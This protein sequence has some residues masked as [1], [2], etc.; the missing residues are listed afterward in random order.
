MI[1]SP[2]RSPSLSPASSSIVS[3]E[4]CVISTLLIPEY[5][6]LSRK[7]RRAPDTPLRWR[8]LRCPDTVKVL[9]DRPR[10]L[11]RFQLDITDDVA[12]HDELKVRPGMVRRLE[13]LRQDVV[14]VG[15][16]G[17][18]D[19]HLMED[20]L[21]VRSDALNLNGRHRPRVIA[22]LRVR[23]AMQSCRRSPKRGEDEFLIGRPAGGLTRDELMK[24]DCDG[25]C[26][27]STDH[28]SRRRKLL[29]SPRS[30]TRW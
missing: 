4:S 16:L 9:D 21:Q 24:R 15:V 14:T 19:E 12:V 29:T 7:I 8:A 22:E 20:S 27:A 18:H 2:T 10:V 6:T 5:A 13:E 11:N 23:C 26:G 30:R 1:A 28:V 25:H 17:L 3:R